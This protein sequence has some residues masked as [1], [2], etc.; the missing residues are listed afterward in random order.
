MENQVSTKPGA[1]QSPRVV[2]LLRARSHG[3]RLRFADAIHLATALRVDA[4]ALVAYDAEL[5]SAAKTAGI[6]VA[7]PA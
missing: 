5:C 4:R 1:V 3:R 6:T 2:R 7:S